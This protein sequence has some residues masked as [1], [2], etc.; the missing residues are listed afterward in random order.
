MV[1]AVDTTVLLDVLVPGSEHGEESEGRLARA[2]LAGAIVVCPTVVAELGAH[3]S[4]EAELRAFLR[5]TGLRVDPFGLG[6]LQLAGQAWKTHRKRR[7]EVPCPSCGER[8]A[9]P[10]VLGDFLVGAHAASQADQLLTR[11]RGFY[12]AHFPKLKLG[13]I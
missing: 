4:R 8:V 13:P 11:D 9:R 12:R 6:S 5:D 10:S 2:M 3:F 7:T 1:T